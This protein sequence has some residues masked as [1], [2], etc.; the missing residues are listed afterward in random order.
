M[1]TIFVDL[2]NISRI[3]KF[4]GIISRYEGDF[5]IVQ[6]KYT[7]DAKSIVGIFSLDL[8]KPVQLNIEVENPDL[9]R[10]LQFFECGE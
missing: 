3:K 6:G 5:D 2:S 9:Q 8:S 10:E 7:V 4:A 1:K